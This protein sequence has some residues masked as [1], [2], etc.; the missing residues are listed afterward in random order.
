L[1]LGVQGMFFKVHGSGGARAIKNAVAAVKT[2]G[3]LD[4]NAAIEQRL[5][6]ER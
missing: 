4:V 3:K 6:V 5:K 2:I 1:L